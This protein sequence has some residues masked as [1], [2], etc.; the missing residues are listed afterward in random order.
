MHGLSA[1]VKFVIF[2]LPTV[3]SKLII[4]QLH[5]KFLLL[6]FLFIILKKLH[7][8]VLTDCWTQF[9]KKLKTL[10]KAK[11]HKQTNASFFP[12]LKQAPYKFLP[13]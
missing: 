13:I 10:S 4:F 6:A 8:Q 12:N 3:P 2:Y 7:F 9:V 5:R 11:G 1:Y